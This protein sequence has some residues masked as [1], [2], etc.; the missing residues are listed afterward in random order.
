MEGSNLHSFI[1]EESNLVLTCSTMSLQLSF[2][3]MWT[4][5]CLYPYN[6]V[7]LF[8]HILVLYNHTKTHKLQFYSDLTLI[9]LN[10]E[11]FEFF[12]VSTTNKY[13]VDNFVVWYFGSD[14]KYFFLLSVVLNLI[15]LCFLKFFIVFSKN[16]LFK[17]FKQSFSKIFFAFL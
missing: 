3:F 5:K 1:I 17:D 12:L 14:T 8:H 13:S 9:N 11:M 6:N 2:V 15:S 16:E 7:L 10:E 4:V